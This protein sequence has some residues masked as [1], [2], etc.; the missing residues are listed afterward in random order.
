MLTG[1]AYGGCNRW[2]AQ[3]SSTDS[4]QLMSLFQ[5]ILRELFLKEDGKLK[6]VTLCESVQRNKAIHHDVRCYLCVYAACVFV[7]D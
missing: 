7:D 2:S 1:S 6:K 3:E 5:E 4:T